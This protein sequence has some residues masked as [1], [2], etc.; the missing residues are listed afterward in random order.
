M[1]DQKSLN[2]LQQQQ[3]Q[4]QQ[5]SKLAKKNDLS[6]SQFVRST[7]PLHAKM[8]EKHRVQSLKDLLQA[9]LNAELRYHCKVVEELSAVLHDLALV[10]DDE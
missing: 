6:V 4:L 3:A 1:L 2:K 9:L 8:F 7:L 5:Q 10:E